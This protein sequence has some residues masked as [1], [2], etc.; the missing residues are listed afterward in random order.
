MPKVNALVLGSGGGGPVI[1]LISGAAVDIRFLF[2]FVTTSGFL[3][4]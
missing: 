4:A 2:G 1:A 3:E